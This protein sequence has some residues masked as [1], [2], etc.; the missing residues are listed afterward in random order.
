MTA[1]IAKPKPSLAAA[2]L[3]PLAIWILLSVIGTV[4]LVRGFSN[5]SSAIDGF[6]RVEPNASTEVTLKSSGGY[7]VWAEFPESGSEFTPVPTGITVT[8][9]DAD[10]QAVAVDDYNGSISYSDGGTEGVAINTFNIDEPGDYAITSS[11]DSFATEPDALA[12]GTVNPTAEVGKGFGWFFGLG[13]LGFL[14][15]LIL[16]IIMLVRRGRSKR[17]LAPAPAYAG[18]YP[19]PAY[20]GG[21]PQPQPGYP[22]PQPG[23]PQPQ[24][25]YGAAGYPPPPAATPPPAPTP[26]PFGAPPPSSTPPPPGSWPPPPS[27]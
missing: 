5:Y 19:Q 27:S 15:A 13:T 7:R 2:I 25:G 8:V 11:L 10:G 3:I 26:G 4:M 14:I 22:Q 17:Q 23:Y 21:Y 18:G 16:F 12:I 1:P 6:A 20:G 9:T 24:P